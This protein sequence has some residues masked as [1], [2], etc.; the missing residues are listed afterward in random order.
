MPYVT[1]SPVLYGRVR[2]L[3]KKDKAKN[4]PWPYLLMIQV[5]A[6]CPFALR[7]GVNRALHAPCR[8]RNCN[9]QGDRS[10]ARTVPA[11]PRRIRRR[12][13]YAFRAVRARH[14]YPSRPMLGAPNGTKGSGW[15]GSSSLFA[16]KTLVHPQ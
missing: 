12:L 6:K 11:S 10:L 15:A 16:G 8:S 4:T 5:Q 1:A 7:A 9:R 2:E 14:D 13:Q 3:T